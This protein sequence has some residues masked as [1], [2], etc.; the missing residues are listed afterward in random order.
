MRGGVLPVSDEEVLIDFD[1]A[2]VHS[3]TTADNLDTYAR[4]LKGALKTRSLSTENY[5]GWSSR[6]AGRVKSSII[7]Q[8][9]CP[10]YNTSQSCHVLILIHIFIVPLQIILLHQPLDPL[11]DAADFGHKVTLDGLDHGHLEFLVCQLLLRLHRPDDRGVQVI[12]A[13]ALD[14]DLRAMSFLWLSKV[15]VNFCRLVSKTS[16][17][18]Q[19]V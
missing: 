12:L 7:S 16:H 10:P 13:I 6:T 3:R 5:H 18:I 14:Q 1:L 19:E 15:C 8:R 4:S 2:A 17:G 9:R 11:L